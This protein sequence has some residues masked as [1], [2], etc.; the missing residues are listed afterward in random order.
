MQPAISAAADGI[1]CSRRRRKNADLKRAI[2]IEWPDRMRT[3]PCSTTWARRKDW[4]LKQPQPGIVYNQAG[5]F[6]AR[7]A[8]VGRIGRRRP[9]YLIVAISWRVNLIQNLPIVS[10]CFDARLFRLAEAAGFQRELDRFLPECVDKLRGDAAAVIE[11]PVASAKMMLG[12]HLFHP[13]LCITD[14]RHQGILRR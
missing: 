9:P 4:T 13:R 5:N 2:Y 8:L 6:N 3:G 14:V 7:R 1:G 11:N 12:R 10:M